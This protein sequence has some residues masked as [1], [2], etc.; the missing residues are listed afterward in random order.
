MTCL[1]RFQRQS[2][3]V[4]GAYAGQ[5]PIEATEGRTDGVTQIS[6]IHGAVLRVEG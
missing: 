6:W 3:Q 2:G 1:Q 4:V 5:A